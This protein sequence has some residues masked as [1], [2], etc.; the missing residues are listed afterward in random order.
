MEEFKI[1]YFIENIYDAPVRKANF[2]LLVIPYSDA[3]QTVTAL[4]MACSANL[5]AHI[6]KNIFGFDTINYYLAHPFTEFWFRL[7]A[8][9]EKQVINPYTV[10]PL[11]PEET[12]AYI[13][14]DDFRIE[15]HLFLRPTSLTSMPES[16]L[17][18]PVYTKEN[19]LFDYLSELNIFIHQLL[20][21]APESTDVDTPIEEVLKLRKGVCQDFAHLFISVCRLN[22]IPARYVSG[23]LNQGAGFTGASQL[24]AW[25]EVFIPGSGWTGFDATNRLL[26]DHHYIKIAHG[27][28]FRDCSPIIGVLETTGLQKSIHS[29]T[30]SNQ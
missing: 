16:N 22:G 7:T 15:H 4:K 12:F 11:L 5:E 3:S 8:S 14:S 28:D 2:Q 29:V 17:S 18:F 13:H 9:L 24:H 23:Y 30:V 20:E 6:S 26:A 10:S 25:A 27:T 21:Y 1:D 19:H